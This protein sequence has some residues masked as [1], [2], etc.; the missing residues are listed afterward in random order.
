MQLFLDYI[1]I[2]VFV[3]AYFNKDIYFAT[4]A[5]M[6]T[7]PVVLALQW[8]ITRKVSKIYLA[9]T[10]LVLI[11]G[12]VTLFLRNPTFIY[13]KPTVL[14]WVV[15]AVFLGSQWIGEQPIV[16]RMLGSAVELNE[17]QWNRLNQIWVGFFTVS[18]AA[19]I[20]VAYSFP[21]EFWVKFKLF[22]MLGMTF[23]FVLIQGIWLAAMTKSQEVA[24]EDSET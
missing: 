12:G 18:G 11:L 22:G 15:A 10:A 2:V 16:R 5:L 9:S 7:M 8:L 17:S 6:I 23:V 20:Y 1:P 24:S 19:N 4:T 13:W 21:E 3:V 14:N